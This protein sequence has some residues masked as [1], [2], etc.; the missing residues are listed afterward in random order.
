MD[1][2]CIGITFWHFCS[3]FS[4]HLLFDIQYVDT[5]ICTVISAVLLVWLLMCM[6]VCVTK[7]VWV[8]FWVSMFYTTTY[9]SVFLFS[10]CEKEGGGRRWGFIRESV[11]MNIMKP[12]YPVAFFLQWCPFFPQ[13]PQYKQATNCSRD[14]C[15]HPDMTFPP[16][17]PFLKGQI[18]WQGGRSGLALRSRAL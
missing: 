18:L 7:S 6:Y 12:D 3:S 10:L 4:C 1:K 17:P 13:H 11:M 5:D 9:S 15:G 8:K 14:F 2:L 16:P